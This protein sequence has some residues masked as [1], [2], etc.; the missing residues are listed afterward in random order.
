MP[1]V[2]IYLTNT[3]AD[4][5]IMLASCIYLSEAMASALTHFI[6]SMTVDGVAQKADRSRSFRTTNGAKALLGTKLELRSRS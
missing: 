1:G 3:S 6:H 4:Y 2:I 5:A